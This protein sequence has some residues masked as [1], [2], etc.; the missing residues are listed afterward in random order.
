M[1]RH[2]RGCW[3]CHMRTQKAAVWNSGREP[4]PG[5]WI[6]TLVFDSQPPEVY[7]INSCY[8]SYSVSRISL[9]QPQLTKTA[10]M[11]WRPLSTLNLLLPPLSD[12]AIPSV[13]DGPLV[14]S[15]EEVAL[16]KRKKPICFTLHFSPPLVLLLESDPSMFWEYDC[17]VEYTWRFI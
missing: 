1:K 10:W 17:Q 14:T 6:S 3:D 7:E 2:Q 16:Q 4:S 5:N 12:E 8:V 9:W 15:D 11:I 13:L